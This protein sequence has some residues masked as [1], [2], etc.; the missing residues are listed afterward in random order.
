MVLGAGCGQEPEASKSDLASVVERDG[1]RFAGQAIPADV[2]ELISPHRVVVVGEHHQIREHYELM[3]EL[4]R[5]LHPRGLRQVLLEW[6][7]VLDWLLA[8]YVED[9]G[10][11]PD[12]TPSVIL[13]GA[14]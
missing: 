4:V 6:P 1:V 5:A 11:E 13:G 9:R 2:L 7:H 12:W 10:L 14:M 3:S 8:D